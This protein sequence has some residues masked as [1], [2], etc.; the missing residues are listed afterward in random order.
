MSILQFTSHDHKYTSIDPNDTTQWLS[1]TRFV[2]QFKPHFD[3]GGMAQKSSRNKKSKWYG[4]KEEEIL[5][6]WAAEA[7]RST[8]LGTWYHSK[9]EEE[10]LQKPHHIMDNHFL[11]I[12]TPIVKDEIK[13]SPDQQ[14]SEGIY[15]EHLVYHQEA[16][17]CG[18]SDLVYVIGNKVHLG[19]YKT[20]KKIEQ[21]GFRDFHGRT[22][23]MKAPLDHLD[24]CNFTH[25]SLQL[26][27][28]MY[29][30]LQH[31]PLLECGT[32]WIEHV[33]FE[34]AG[35]DQF[36]YPLIRLDDKGNPIVK[37]VLFY[38]VTYLQSE[39]EQLMHQK[40]KPTTDD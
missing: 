32:M 5:M 24:D 15:P 35:R 17:L 6:V 38:N 7:K 30:I 22:A 11:P 36:D 26:S 20:N 12:I 16:G 2:E 13:Y 14:L 21:Y 29:M 25:Y 3:S 4:M 28:Y 23:K 40:Y 9:R 27:I 19:D 10:L 31:N 33:M 18:Q 34:E 37:D 1:V 39:V 8:D